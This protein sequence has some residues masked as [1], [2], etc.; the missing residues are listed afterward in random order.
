MADIRKKKTEKKPPKAVPGAAWRYEDTT[1]VQLCKGAMIDSS[2]YEI[3]ENRYF[4]LLIK[5]FIVYLI[6]AGGIGAYLTALDISFNQ[7]IFNIII[8]IIK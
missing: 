8:L 3:S 1:P 7:I 4:T 5:G 6:T 2:V